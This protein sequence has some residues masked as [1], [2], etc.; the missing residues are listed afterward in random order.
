MTFTG[1]PLLY[2]L[3][4]LAAGAGI[5]AAAHLL[6]SRFQVRRTATVI[7]WREIDLQKRHRIL[8]GRFRHP[9]TF[10]FLL[11]LIILFILA[12]IR[13]Q[14]QASSAGGGSVHVIV[15]RGASMGLKS[16]SGG[17]RLEKALEDLRPILL[18]AGGKEVR[19][20]FVPCPQTGLS[21]VFR[22]KAA[23]T[24]FLTGLDITACSCPSDLTDVIRQAVSGLSSDPELKVVLLSDHPQRAARLF[25]DFSESKT[26][27]SVEDLSS[28]FVINNYGS[29]VDNTAVLSCRLSVDSNRENAVLK[30]TAGRWAAQEAPLTVEVTDNGGSKVI[31]QTFNIEAGRVE[32]F[33]INADSL[34]ESDSNIEYTLSFES[35]DEFKADQMAR[36]FRISDMFSGYTYRSGAGIPYPAEVFLETQSFMVAAKKGAN[37]DMIFTADS[38]SVKSSGKAV[39]F[40]RAGVACEAGQKII[41]HAGSAIID[42]LNFNRIRTGAGNGFGPQVEGEPLLFSADGHVL[43]Y[44]SFAGQKRCVYLASSLFGEGGNLYT[45]AVFPEFMARLSSAVLRVEDPS[46]ARKHLLSLNDFNWREDYCDL[47]SG[48]GDYQSGRLESK[49]AFLHIDMP[50]VIILILLILCITEVFLY[51][52]GRIV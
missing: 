5:L 26:G 28:R 42:D 13:P 50:H 52:R 10:I 8:G 48:S 45:D 11:A 32:D 34:L 9:Y 35:D 27:S 6:R 41:K 18:G 30:V 43:A 31:S 24:N 1:I 47:S 7:F 16:G 12:L 39:I 49:A 2:A 38:E 29:A 46:A 40:A 20:S 4:I 21:S 37:A 15:D 33:V 3:G 19:V 14:M 25:A 23:M 22:D 44:T 51:S 17:T 36:K